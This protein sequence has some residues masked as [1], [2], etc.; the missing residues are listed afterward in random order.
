M[1]DDGGDVVGDDHEEEVE[2]RVYPFGGRESL[3]YC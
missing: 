1:T 3:V 2:V